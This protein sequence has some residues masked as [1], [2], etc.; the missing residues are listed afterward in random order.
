VA[1]GGTAPNPQPYNYFAWVGASG[2]RGF[3][4]PSVTTSGK[5]G[6][7]L[8]SVTNTDSAANYI[9][10]TPTTTGN[11]PT[12]SFGGSDGTVSGVI[13]TQNGNFYVTAKNSDTSV[14]NLLTL[15]HNAAAKNNLKISNAGNGNGVEITTVSSD[16]ESPNL[17]INAAGK[18]F[19]FNIPT[20][21]PHISGA[22]WNNAG[23]LKLSAG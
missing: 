15:T 2:V 22:V 1:S 23:S 19:L 9:T 20:A 8:F 6:Q 21:D 13:Q 17:F 18:L 10:A 12:L 11:P 3:A 14:S 4:T 7:A 16:A 5:T